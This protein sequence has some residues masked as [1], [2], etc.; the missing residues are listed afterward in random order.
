MRCVRA[1][2]SQSVSDRGIQRVIELISEPVH[3]LDRGK[4]H[5]SKAAS[6]PGG[7]RSRLACLHV[8]YTVF[9]F[10]RPVHIVA[11]L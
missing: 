11:V 8:S 6:I 3:A 9:H 2:V 4:Q 1:S 5:W 10:C 7:C